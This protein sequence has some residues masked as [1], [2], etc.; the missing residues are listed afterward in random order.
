MPSYQGV[1]GVVGVPLEASD[2]PSVSLRVVSSLPLEC[3][4]PACRVTAITLV[5]CSV[6]PGRDLSNDINQAHAPR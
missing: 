5:S 4:P 2:I 3:E 6:S 1:T